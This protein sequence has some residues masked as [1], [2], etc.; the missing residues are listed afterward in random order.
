MI[1]LDNDHYR[2][3][4]IESFFF[5]ESNPYI[6]P[7]IQNITNDTVFTINTK[8]N[9]IEKIQLNP[10]F[11]KT[12]FNNYENNLRDRKKQYQRSFFETMVEQYNLKTKNYMKLKFLNKITAFK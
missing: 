8:R 4:K 1:L 2:K 10:K 9:E 3:K 6:P 11:S 12:T 5:E 7:K